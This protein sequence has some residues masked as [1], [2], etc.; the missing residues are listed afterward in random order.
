MLQCMRGLRMHFHCMRQGSVPV[1]NT[2]CNRATAPEPGWPARGAARR[3]Q[4]SAQDTRTPTRPYAGHAREPLDY[5]IL[6]GW[7][8]HSQKAI[9]RSPALPATHCWGQKIQG[10][11]PR[12]NRG[13]SAHTLAVF[14]GSSGSSG[15]GAREVLTAQKRHP[16]V[17]VSPMSMIVAVAVCPSPP[18]QHSLAGHAEKRT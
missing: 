7:L 11:R 12:C 8:A 9:E 1:N 3:H 6:Q 10:Q 2:R 17:H 14:S 5:N 15:G 13:A 16:R 4:H 18:P